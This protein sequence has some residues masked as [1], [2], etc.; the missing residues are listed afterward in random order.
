MTVPWFFI[1]SNMETIGGLPFWA[2]YALLTTFVYAV[3]MFYFL[4]KYW[5]LSASDKSLQE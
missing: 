3:V 4:H 5:L 2:F 1:S